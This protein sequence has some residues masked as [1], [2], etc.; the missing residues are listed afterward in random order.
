MATRI[1]FRQQNDGDWV[2]ERYPLIGSTPSITFPCLSIS[3][4]EMT[5]DLITMILHG[6]DPSPRR[7]YPSEKEN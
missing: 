6:E 4:L 3:E 5:R 1:A 2:M 7:V